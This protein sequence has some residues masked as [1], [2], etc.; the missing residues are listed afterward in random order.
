MKNNP[1]L[2]KEV[3]F[4]RITKGLIIGLPVVIMIFVIGNHYV[5]LIDDILRDYYTRGKQEKVLK[6]ENNKVLENFSLPLDSAFYADEYIDTW[7]DEREGYRKFPRH[8]DSPSYYF[9]DAD[10]VTLKDSWLLKNGYELDFVCEEVDLKK[11]LDPAEYLTCNI[12]YNGELVVDNVYYNAYC[13][14]FEDFT[15]CHGE[16][17][18]AVFSEPYLLGSP[19]FLATEYRPSGFDSAISVFNLEDGE[20]KRLPFETREG[21]VY[22]A[23]GAREFMF[24]L[25]EEQDA[26]NAFLQREISTIEL[27][28]YQLNPSWL[29]EE[30][31][32]IYHIWRFEKD[33]FIER[34]SITIIHREE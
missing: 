3:K 6:T 8:I 32:G 34:K 12:Y 22:E 30:I 13:S 27:V 29:G 7:I 26:N 25:Y 28:N 18:F 24:E 15:N 23:I 14:D 10:V 17:S 31:G 21:D 5:N 4:K 1:F 19:E 20:A 33:R 2:N 16:V 11:R 9:K